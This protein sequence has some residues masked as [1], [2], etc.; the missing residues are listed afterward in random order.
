MKDLITIIIPCYNAENSILRT[1]KSVLEQDYKSLEIIIIDD[2]SIDNSLDVIDM[3]KKCDNR[4]R[5]VSQKNAGVSVARNKGLS[6]ANGE[7][8]MFIDADDN[9]TSPNA[10]SSMYEEMK[11]VDADMVVCR[12][13]HQC[14]DQYLKAGLYDLSIDKNLI[15]FVQD[16]FTLSMPW[17][18]IYKKSCLTESF[19]EGVKFTEDELFNLYNIHNFKRVAVLDK[20]YHN[21]YSE[22]YNAKHKQISAVNSQLMGTNTVWKAGMETDKYRLEAINKFH[23]NLKNEMRYIR[24]FDFFFWDIFLLFKSRMSVQYVVENCNRNLNEN[25]FQETLKDKKRLGLKLKEITNE[26]LN[27]F[28]E[29]CYYAFIDI[30]LLNKNLSLFKVSTSIFAKLFYEFKEKVESNDIVGVCL[31]EMVLNSTNEAKYVNSL[32]KTDKEI[33]KKLFKNLLNSWNN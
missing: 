23:K 6:L 31:N 27:E 33:F 18:K 16:F 19:I 32:M 11:K 26:K 5:V 14:F 3:F 15:K 4:I 12:F 17:N 21:Y 9:Y 22:P 2:G 10:I 20:V 13:V 8:V 1:L 7:Y 30:K 24:S 28:V 29:L 25:L